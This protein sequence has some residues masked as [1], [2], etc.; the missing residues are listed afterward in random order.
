MNK[1]LEKKFDV[2][3]CWH[4][5]FGISDKYLKHLL[6]RDKKIKQFIDEHFVNKEEV[7]EVLEEFAKDSKKYPALVLDNID[8]RYNLGFNEALKQAITLLENK[9]DL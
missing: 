7:R 1:A 4:A 9:I 3:F 5:R 2:E 8:E 6:D